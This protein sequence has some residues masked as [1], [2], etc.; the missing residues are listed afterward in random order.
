[1]CAR[2]LAVDDGWALRAA[3]VEVK[4]PGDALATH[5]K[6]WLDVLVAGGVD[7][8]VCYVREPSGDGA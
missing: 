3:L 2:R 6:L 4:G 5:Q 8:R 7:A 1:M